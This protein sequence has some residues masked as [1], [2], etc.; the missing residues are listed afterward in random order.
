[1]LLALA[2][3]NVRSVH[4]ASGHAVA[5]DNL[6]DKPTSTQEAEEGCGS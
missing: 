1:M 6:S 5:P 4:A 2:T 3:L